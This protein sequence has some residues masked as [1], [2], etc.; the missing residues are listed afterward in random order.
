[1]LLQRLIERTCSVALVVPLLHSGNTGH[2]K[3]ASPV[4][5]S[6]TPRKRVVIVTPGSSIKV[7]RKIVVLRHPV[8]PLA[9]VEH[10]DRPVLPIEDV[11][12]FARD[13]AGFH[14][15]DLRGKV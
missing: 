8:R 11:Q 7:R 2:E 3:Q 5:V 14:I 15:S 13:A 10:L 9:E 1:M 4:L 6:D 12:A